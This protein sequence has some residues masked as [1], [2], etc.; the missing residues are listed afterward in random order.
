MK[1][2][3]IVKEL[4]LAETEGW[5][6]IPFINGNNTTFYSDIIENNSITLAW[7]AVHKVL[8][9]KDINLH[10]F[11]R[12][13][14]LQIGLSNST[15]RLLIATDSKRWF[16]SQAGEEKF[17][18]IK[19]SK[20]LILLYNEIKGII[21]YLELS[22]H[23]HHLLPR[24]RSTLLKLKNEVRRYGEYNPE[25]KPYPTGDPFIGTGEISINATYSSDAYSISSANENLL[26]QYSKIL[27]ELLF[28]SINK[29]QM[30]FLL[31]FPE[32]DVYVNP[33]IE[34][35]K[36]LVC[37]CKPIEDINQY[38]GKQK[39]LF[40]LVD[41]YAGTH[42]HFP[43]HEITQREIIPN[44]VKVNVAL[45]NEFLAREAF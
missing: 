34:K 27:H 13:S 35:N 18:Q 21:N 30:Q 2:F 9:D 37:I 14:N 15:P 36:L 28:K 1:I 44:L 19:L 43:T 31:Q 22:N 8:D 17:T 7:L 25:R 3:D 24:L 40:L 41:K 29:R 26:S 20:L 6:Y 10:H 16:V 32:N 33:N 12:E 39:L 5:K 38:N 4:G 45:V 11:K 23:A 42:V